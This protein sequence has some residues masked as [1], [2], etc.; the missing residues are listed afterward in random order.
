MYKVMYW[1]RRIRCLFTGHN[2]CTELYSQDDDYCSRCY[3]DCPQELVTLPILLN[4]VYCWLVE[5][6]WKWFERFDLWIGQVE[7]RRRRLP[8]WWEY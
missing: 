1:L 5:R 7:W 3:A 6:D 4:R 8:S 2:V